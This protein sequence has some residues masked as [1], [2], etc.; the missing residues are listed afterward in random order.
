MKRNRNLKLA[1]FVIL[2]ALASG[3]VATNAV[4]QQG[5]PTEFEDSFPIEG[6]CA[7]PLLVELNGKAKTIELP[8]GRT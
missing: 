4:A 5:P 8:G 1:A 3:P 6:M 2:V 7:F